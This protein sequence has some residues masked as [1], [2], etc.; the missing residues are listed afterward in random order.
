MR[1]VKVQKDFAAGNTVPTASLAPWARAFRSSARRTRTVISQVARSTTGGAAG[2]GRTGMTA[3][4]RGAGTDSIGL[5]D[6]LGS[7]GTVPFGCLLLYLRIRVALGVLFWRVFWGIHLK[8]M[9]IDLLSHRNCVQLSQS[10]LATSSHIRVCLS[11]AALSTVSLLLL[12]SLSPVIFVSIRWRRVRRGS[13]SS[14]GPRPLETF[15]HGPVSSGPIKSCSC[16][17]KLGDISR[18][19]AMGFSAIWPWETGP[20]RNLN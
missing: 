10:A 1:E 18:I 5:A 11:S 15:A 4:S 12:L 14:L 19:L 20:L 2:A 17:P 3:A 7:V 8:S 9:Y 6:D 16:V 13:P